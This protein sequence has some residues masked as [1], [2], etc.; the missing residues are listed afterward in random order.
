M[1]SFEGGTMYY[2]KIE[3]VITE[4][5]RLEKEKEDLSNIENI[6]EIIENQIKNPNTYTQGHVSIC[7]EYDSYS[8][9]ARHH[10]VK[11]SGLDWN[12][13]KPILEKRKK[14]IVARFEKLQEEL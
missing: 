3:S 7:C 4:G 6:I 9:R 12:D 2:S 14:E 1:E 13:I 8:D 5:K 11:V 10:E